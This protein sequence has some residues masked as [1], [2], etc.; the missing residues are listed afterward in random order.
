MDDGLLYCLQISFQWTENVVRIPIARRMSQWTRI[1]IAAI[2]FVNGAEFSGMMNILSNTNE[3]FRYNL[4]SDDTGLKYKQGVIP[5][6]I[7]VVVHSA[8]ENSFV[9]R[10]MEVGNNKIKK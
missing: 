8:A 2:Y 6:W 5:D 4:K 9:V 7:I 1:P 10:N 3:F